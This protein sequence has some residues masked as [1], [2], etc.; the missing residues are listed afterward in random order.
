MRPYANQ[1]EVPACPPPDQS[2]SQI[3]DRISRSEENL[4]VLHAALDQLETRLTTVLTPVGP[5][6]TGNGSK[7]SPSPCQSHVLDRLTVVDMGIVAATE[8]L[9]D[10]MR[11]VEV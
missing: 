3:R 4:G 9:R 7:D 11:R 8:R 6:A 10:L 2:P 1:C 5:A